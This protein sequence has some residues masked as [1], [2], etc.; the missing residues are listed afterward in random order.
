MKLS[1]PT[2]ARRS[3]VSRHSPVVLGPGRAGNRPQRVNWQSMRSLTIRSAMIEHARALAQERNGLLAAA[4]LDELLDAK[5]LIA[6]ADL[7]AVARARARSPRNAALEH[8]RLQYS[9]AE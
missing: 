8:H 9:A 6:A 4:Q 3:F 1:T 2:A 5:L 7:A